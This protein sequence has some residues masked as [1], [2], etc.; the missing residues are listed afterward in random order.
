MKSAASIFELGGDSAAQAWRTL[1]P[2]MKAEIDRLKVAL[3]EVAAYPV[4]D[5]GYQDIAR[6]ALAEL[7]D[8]PGAGWRE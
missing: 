5:D 3:R 8:P 4:G 2:V 7:P 6:A 1:G